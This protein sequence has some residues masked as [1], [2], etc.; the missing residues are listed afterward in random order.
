MTKADIVLLNGRFLTLSDRATTGVGAVAVRNGRILAVGDSREMRLLAPPSAC[1]Y[2]LQGRFVTPGFV[3]SHT[4]VALSGLRG[5]IEVDLTGCSRLNELLLLL[6]RRVADAPLGTWVRGSGW[7][8]TKL[9]V[10]PTRWALDTVAPDHPVLLTHA[11]GHSL[12]A[13]TRALQLGGVDR[14]TVERLG[15][16]IERDPI[17][18]EPTGL[19]KEFGAMRLLTEHVPQVTVEEY[20]RAIEWAQHEYLRHGVTACKESYPFWEFETVAAACDNLALHSRLKLKQILLRQVETPEEVTQA[21]T[22]AVPQR[23]ARFGGIKIFLDGSLVAR[24]AWLNDPYAAGGPPTSGYAVLDPDMFRATVAAAHAAGLGVSVHAIG[25][26]A[27]EVAVAALSEHPLSTKWKR[28]IVHALLATKAAISDM[29]AAGISVETQSTF[30]QELGEG[31]A[32]VLDSNRLQR[33]IPLRR[34]LDAGVVV[35]LGS[36]WPTCRPS[37]VRG[38]YGAIARPSPPGEDETTFGTAERVSIL[39]ALR[40]YT[41]LGARSV[42][43][44]ADS[45]SIE[46]GKYADLVVWDENLLSVDPDRFVELAPVATIVEGEVAYGSVD[47]D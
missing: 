1:I 20:E 38:I 15:S 23:R 17:S 5:A 24:T 41:I 18:G 14:D 34:L 12:V 29:A 11:T 22:G 9:D 27:V 46:P 26:R 13:N 10:S 16:A 32:R 43:I 35:A 40:M 21:A 36:D 4:H 28:S 7:S 39:E 42:G 19:L 31:Y 47:S 2:D 6:E 8:E 3:D 30:L 33:L 37:V 25:D 45:G 44:D